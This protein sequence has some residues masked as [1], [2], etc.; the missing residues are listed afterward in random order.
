M[1]GK[2][3]VLGCWLWPKKD[4][5]VTENGPRSWKARGPTK[6]NSNGHQMIRALA[7]GSTLSFVK[8]IHG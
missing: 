5:K 8:H 3:R 2:K 4:C 7:Q 6:N 1:E